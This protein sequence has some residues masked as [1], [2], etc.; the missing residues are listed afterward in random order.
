MYPLTVILHAEITTDINYW[1]NSVP[2]I[3]HM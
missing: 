3:S 1:E 2:T